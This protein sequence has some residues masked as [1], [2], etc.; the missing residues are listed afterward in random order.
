M[1]STA[2]IRRIS[3]FKHTRSPTCSALYPN[4]IPLQRDGM[5]KR[6]YTLS[7]DHQISGSHKSNPAGQA[8]ANR[9]ASFST[10]QRTKTIRTLQTTPYS[11]QDRKALSFLPTQ[12]QFLGGLLSRC[13][14]RLCRSSS[15]LFDQRD[16]KTF[17]SR[18]AQFFFYHVYALPV[19]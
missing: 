12:F 4:F 3:S 19:L 14:C 1:H 11:C 10:F 6:F 13:I 15:G 18:E 17:I 5:C 9:R 8:N 7:C 2:S 16:T